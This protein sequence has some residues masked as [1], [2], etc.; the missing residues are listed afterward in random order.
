MT[1]PLPTW[2]KHQCT[3]KW[4]K[5][6]KR[7]A[8]LVD[9]DCQLLVLCQRLTITLIL[10]SS[11]NEALSESI[12]PIRIISPVELSIVNKFSAPANTF[13]RTSHQAVT[14]LIYFY[15]TSVQLES[16]IQVAQIQVAYLYFKNSFTPH[17]QYNFQCSFKSIKV[18]TTFKP[19]QKERLWSEDSVAENQ[20]QRIQL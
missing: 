2:P 13:K 6:N 15:E 17:S 5:N 7:K 18:F 20:S 19:W 14:P 16:K 11:L 9:F 3:L 12:W 1:L 10:Y 4:Y 8:R